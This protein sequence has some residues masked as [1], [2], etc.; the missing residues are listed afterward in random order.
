LGPAGLLELD[1]F[2][3]LSRVCLLQADPGEYRPGREQRY[4]SFI[5]RKE[6]P[7]SGRF[8]NHPAQLSRPEDSGDIC[9]GDCPI[10]TRVN[11]RAARIRQ[12]NFANQAPVVFC[13]SPFIEM[14][15]GF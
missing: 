7:D 13:Q 14:I 11:G 2:S 5:S 15:R 10:S 9:T 12:R 8:N 6:L 1:Q 4:F 3:V